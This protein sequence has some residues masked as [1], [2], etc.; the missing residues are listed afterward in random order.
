MVGGRAGGVKGLGIAGAGGIAGLGGVTGAAGTVRGILVPWGTWPDLSL[1][2]SSC[3][4]RIDDWYSLGAE[5]TTGAG[6]GVIGGLGA[7]GTDE[8]GGGVGRGG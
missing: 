6:G 8:R 1:D 2:K 4:V 5:G 3:I 7:A